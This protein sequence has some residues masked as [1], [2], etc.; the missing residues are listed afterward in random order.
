MSFIAE[1]LHLSEAMQDEE[2]NLSSFD[3]RFTPNLFNFLWVKKLNLSNNQNLI[4]IDKS[5]MPQFLI[6]LDIS[7]TGLTTIYKNDF[8]ETLE[9]LIA[10][11][12]KV[13]K[14]ISIPETLKH[15]ELSKDTTDNYLSIDRTANFANLECL[16][17]NSTSIQTLS[18]IDYQ[19]Q[20]RI[21]HFNDSNIVEFHPILFTNLTE[22][23]L[24][25]NMLPVFDGSCLNKLLKLNLE[26]GMIDKIIVP[27]NCVYLNLRENRITE[28]EIPNSVEYLNIADNNL[29]FCPILPPYLR[30]LH[31]NGNPHVFEL[32]SELKY[33]DEIDISST[34][35]TKI[36]NMNDGCRILKAKDLQLAE[37][38]KLPSKL[39][40][41]NLARNVIEN[42]DF[43]RELFDLEEINLSN[44]LISDVSEFCINVNIIKLS[45]NLISYVRDVCF[46]YSLTELHLDRNNIR[47]CDLFFGNI[48]KLNFTGNPL[49]DATI[50]KLQKKYD[51]SFIFENDNDNL[52]S[53]YFNSDDDIWNH[54]V[55]GGSVSG[56]YYWDDYSKTYSKPT[57]NLMTYSK[58]VDITKYSYEAPIKKI[59]KIQI[60]YN[61]Q[62]EIKLHRIIKI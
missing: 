3:L 8:P 41:L 50:D 55:K 57:D 15:L 39:V 53:K 17:M 60:S 32:N 56:G 16:I 25:K 34:G 12:S 49:D 30:V 52:F 38:K 27:P 14:I 61:N 62:F 28:L 22:L 45:N 18:F 42:C 40:K 21:L 19:T 20:M 5:M 43:V 24:A 35:L 9:V 23:S 37:I 48:D 58:P 36:P 51:K 13:R 54:D 33:I 26:D 44:N 47:E 2:L 4:Y 11:K 1:K 6:E 31:I 7:N 46:P 59:D 10:K 29:Y